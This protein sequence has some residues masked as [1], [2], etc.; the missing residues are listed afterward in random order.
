MF[1]IKYKIMRM[2]H[3]I[4]IFAWRATLISN[5]FSYEMHMI[6]IL[7]WSARYAKLSFV[8]ICLKCKQAKNVQALM[9]KSIYYIVHW[10]RSSKGLSRMQN[11]LTENIIRMGDNISRSCKRSETLFKSLLFWLAGEVSCL[12]KEALS[13]CRK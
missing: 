3:Y 8:F 13:P 11:L 9:F 2:T 6:Y 12:A 5:I 1:H 7:K 10:V 4:V